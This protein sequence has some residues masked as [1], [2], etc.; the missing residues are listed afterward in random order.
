MYCPDCGTKNIDDAR[1]CQNCGLSFEQPAKSVTSP[2]PEQS[3]RPEYEQPLPTDQPH[4]SILDGLPDA[5]SSDYADQV[6]SMY[7]LIA[8]FF[9]PVGVYFWAFHRHRRPE[10]ANK[11]LVATLGGFI[12]MLTIF[13]I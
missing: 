4:S 10:A 7:Y 6:S 5:G 1:F 8:F 3:Y 11:L 13:L 9:W 2:R 12:M